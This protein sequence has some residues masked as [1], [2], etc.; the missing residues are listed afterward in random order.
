MKAWKV[1][2]EILFTRTLSVA[3]NM[4][5]T[6]G[7]WLFRVTIAAVLLQLSSYPARAQTDCHDLSGQTISEDDAFFSAWPSPTETPTEVALVIG[8]NYADAKASSAVAPLKNAENDA[9]AMTALLQRR[10]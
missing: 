7:Y 4:L 9:I 2:L 8:N 10:G 3:N 6:W 5:A 1:G